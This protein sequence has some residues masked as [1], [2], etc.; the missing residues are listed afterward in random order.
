MDVD[1]AARDAVVAGFPRREERLP[2]TI[3]RT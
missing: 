1:I 3:E 2:V